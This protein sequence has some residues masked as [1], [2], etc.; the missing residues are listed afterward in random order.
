[1]GDDL[2]PIDLGAGRTATAISAGTSHTC[3]ILDDGSIKCWGWNF[4]GQL[5]QGDTD[6]RGDEPGEMGDALLPIDLGGG[7]VD[8]S[9][10]PAGIT[11]A[12]SSTSTT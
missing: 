1:M 3:V 9:S 7:P 8:R 10:L 4:L 6:D 5:G 2:P 12:P 11:R